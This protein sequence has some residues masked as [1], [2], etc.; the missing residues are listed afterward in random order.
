MPIYCRI[1]ARVHVASH[2]VHVCMQ[3]ASLRLSV[4]AVICTHKISA[5][6]VNNV[7][8]LV[9]CLLAQPWYCGQ[10]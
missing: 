3:N 9:L 1:P 7:V 4:T 6:L 2:A 8:Q 5:Q 10:L